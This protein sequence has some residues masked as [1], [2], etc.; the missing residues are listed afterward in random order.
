VGGLLPASLWPRSPCFSF[1]FNQSQM[2]NAFVC[3]FLAGKFSLQET[4]VVRCLLSL[5]FPGLVCLT[6]V[7]SGKGA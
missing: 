5:S 4:L 2:F 3:S 6:V 7:V 1:H